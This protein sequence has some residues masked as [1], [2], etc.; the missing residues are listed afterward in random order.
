MTENETGDSRV[1]ICLTGVTEQDVEE[2]SE[3]ICDLLRDR[4]LGNR[5]AFRSI[6]IAEGWQWPA[7]DTAAFV[8][9]IKVAGGAVFFPDAGDPR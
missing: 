7:S 9:E 1:S 6:V 4:G 5:D 8:E 3:A 2:L